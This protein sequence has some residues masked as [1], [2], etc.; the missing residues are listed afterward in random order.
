MPPLSL[1]LSGA[2]IASAV[3]A[4]A[5]LA[6]TQALGP[7]SARAA[8]PR[9]EVW[10]T[11]PDGGRKLAHAASLGFDTSPGPGDISIDP[12]DKEQRF[13]GA[14]A[15]LTEASAKLLGQL[16]E[17]R[18]DKLME[19]L[20][21]T[22][23]GG[24]GLDYLRQPLGGN[25]FVARLPY[26]SYEDTKGSFSIARDEK[27]VLPLLRQARKI[28]PGIRIMASPWSAPGWM[29]E[30]DS[31][32]G[33]R[34]APEHQEDFADYLVRALKAYAK[35]GVPVQD[36]T[37]ANEP[38]FQAI[39][40]SMLMSSGQQTALFK[41]LDRKLTA[42]GLDTGLWAFDHNW[43]HPEYALD[44]LRRTAD[45]ERVRGASFHCYGG[46]PE[47]QL[48]VRKAGERVLFTECSG[49]D[50]EDG[51]QDFSQ[52]LGWQT[53]NW[54]IRTLRSGAETVV[55][56]NLALD[57]EGKPHFGYC[58]GCNG[59]VQVDGENVHKNAE[60]YV[61]GHLSKFVDRGARRIGSTSEGSGGV[62]TV[63]FQNPDGSRVCL[64]L[65]GT[66]KSRSF[67]L[68]DEGKS[69]SYKLPRGAVATFAWPGE[70]G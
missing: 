39:Y 7:S 25:D 60:F 43:D 46:R 66:G 36:L 1:P 64:V 14:G 33:G 44:V 52:A 55:L 38:L 19:D 50:G 27:E 47:Q 21:A 28:N 42:A 12:E 58:R 67:T 22:G 62:Q 57:P 30:N 3:S 54:L 48:D 23:E 68:T 37:V 18:R 69:L 70:K 16:P 4:L 63:A 45:I 31:L 51:V 11:T 65:N 35:A 41:I 49:T 20:F 34:L 15:S 40:P 9:A 2:R 6:A 10:V 13:T 61:L 53:A 24:I 59:V 26:F 8:A 17:E 29:K 5:L 32:S 56:W